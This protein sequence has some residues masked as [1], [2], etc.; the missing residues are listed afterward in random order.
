VR[1]ISRGHTPKPSQLAHVGTVTDP[2]R[3]QRGTR[4]AY[5]G[6]ELLGNGFVN[7]VVYDGG[8]LG[9]GAELRGPALVEE[10]F[11]VV[12]LP[13]G[14]TARVDEFGNYAVTLGP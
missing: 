1:L 4:P 8:A 11:T 3:A 2:E 7:A 14:S 6:P 12:V 10:P 13:P 9:P 5:F